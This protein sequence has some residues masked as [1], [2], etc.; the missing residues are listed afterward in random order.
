MNTRFCVWWNRTQSNT[1]EMTELTGF[2]YVHVHG[3]ITKETFQNVRD[4][5][6]VRYNTTAGNVGKIRPAKKKIES[7][8][9][10]RNV[11]QDF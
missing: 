4:R 8:F 1:N 7:T 2:K 3:D 9:R 6:E 5:G 11:T 10:L